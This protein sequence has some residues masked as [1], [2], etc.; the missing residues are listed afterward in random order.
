[1]LRRSLCQQVVASL[2]VFGSLGLMALSS[3]AHA[4]GYN[5]N[6]DYDDEISFEILQDK[7]KSKNVS[8]LDGALAQL[9]NYYLENYVLMYRSRSL[10]QSTFEYPR[11]IVFGKSGKFILAFNGNP[12]HRG[13][14]N[15]EMIQF[16]EKTNRFEFREVTFA[17]GKAPVVSEANPAKCIVCHQSP[18]RTDVDMR[19]NW[20]PY[21]FW[22]GT[23][24]STD[25]ELR[26]V[27]RMN[28]E[29]YKAGNGPLYQPLNVF[30]EQD[31]FLIDEQAQEKAALEKF[32]TEIKPYNRRYSFLP[33]YNIRNPLSLTKIT[34]TLNFR[35]IVRLMRE[36]LGPVF[37]IYKY[38]VAGIARS[39]DSN[40]E[41]YNHRCSELYFPDDTKRIQIAALEKL[42][43]VYPLDFAKKKTYEFHVIPIAKGIELVFE[44]FG[45][46]TSDWSM[47]FKTEGRFSFDKDRFTSPH[48]SGVHLFDALKLVEPE[49]V[50]L[51]CPELKIKSEE[52]LQKYTDSGELTA[53]LEKAEKVRSQ[54]PPKPLI[55]RCIKC[56]VNGDGVTIPHIPF[57]NFA[58]LKPLLQ[59]GKY[60]RGT[61]LEE[62]RY[63]IGDHATSFEQ[64]PPNGQASKTLREDLTAILTNL[65]R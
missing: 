52:L 2:I 57:D 9:P 35:R 18:N 61:L 24:G 54:N 58:E 28:Y 8:T 47:D 13:Y 20:E 65:A 60:P 41:G 7:I 63:R 22:P 33:E 21:N 25:E 29:K 50:R 6:P 51:A 64:M 45:V 30:E 26:P 43:Q 39:G 56:H 59:Q 49:A 5:V 15:L 27:L 10:Q 4:A 62:I 37:D 11:A 55:D 17:D 40:S 36:A 38:A 23:Y 3:Q 46:D 48:D 32:V 1:M 12:N 53:A 44:P 19:P 16:R 31:M 14:N 34:V 42:R